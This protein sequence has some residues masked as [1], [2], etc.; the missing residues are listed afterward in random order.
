MRPPH[1]G[2][3]VVFVVGPTASG[4]SALAN[5][6]CRRLGGETVN[7]DALQVYAG[8]PVATNQEQDQDVRMHLMAC[9][10]A[11]EQMTVTEW[12]EEATACIGDVRGRGAV[13]VVVGGTAYYVMACMMENR[14]RARGL[15][16]EETKRQIENLTLAEKRVLLEQ[17][18]AEKA[19][20]VAATDERKTT[21]ALEKLMAED[22]GKEDDQEERLRYGAATRVIRV[23]FGR[24]WEEKVERRV[25]DMLARG[26]EEEAAGLEDQFRAW[27]IPIDFERGVWQAIGLKEMLNRHRPIADRRVDVVRATLRYARKQERMLRNTLCPRVDHVVVQSGSWMRANDDT[28]VNALVEWIRG[29]PLNESDAAVRWVS[30]VGPPPPPVRYECCGL[31]IF[32][33]KPLAQHRKSKGHKARQRRERLRHL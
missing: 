26:L 25:D 18:S 5:L 29:G 16:T 8:A 13:P 32:G 1:E 23:E 14:H 31:V 3:P 2:P 28:V 20:R 17:L 30:A 24:D 33:D 27:G 22:G 4:K 15:V 19:E 9:R 7:A 11:R 21:R 12:M 6:L 10:E